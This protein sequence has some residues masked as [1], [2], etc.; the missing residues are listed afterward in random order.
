MVFTGKTADEALQYL[1]TLRE[2]V[3]S[4]R[5]LLRKA[6]RRQQGKNKNRSKNVRVSISIGIAS[7][8]EKHSQPLEVISAADKA[9]YRAK[10]QGRNCVKK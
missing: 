8:S 10:K 9:L 5:F 3:A 6:D 7:R 1:E 4:S 2:D